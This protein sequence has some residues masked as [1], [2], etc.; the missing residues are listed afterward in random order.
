V[1]CL[2]I[3]FNALIDYLSDCDTSKAAALTGFF[4]AVPPLLQFLINPFYGSVSLPLPLPSSS[5]MPVLSRA[6]VLWACGVVCVRLHRV[7]SDVGF[8]RRLFLAISTLCMTAQLFIVASLPS[9]SVLIIVA[10]TRGVTDSA[11]SIGAACITDVSPTQDMFVRNFG[12][13]AASQSQSL[14]RIAA[15]VAA[16]AP[17]SWLVR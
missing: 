3:A 15:A 11:F 8:G 2:Q 9:L 13:I 12:V 6:S 4:T 1:L 7:L 10:I 16:A 17:F 14:S 5:P